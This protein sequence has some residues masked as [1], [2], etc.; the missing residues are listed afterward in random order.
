[1]NILF[2]ANT[3]EMYGANNSLVDMLEELTKRNIN[4]YVVVMNNGGLVRKLRKLGIKSFVVPYF[5]NSSTEGSLSYWE[6]FE[7]LVSNIKLLPRIGEIIKKYNIDVIHSNASNIDIG[8]MAAIKYHIPHVWHFREMLYEDYGLKLDFPLVSKYLMKKSERI[9]AISEYVKKERKLGENSRVLYDGFSI[10]KYIISKENYFINKKL[11]ILYCGVISKQKG[12]IDI[13]KAVEY[14]IRSGNRD[15]ELEIVGGETKYWSSIAQ[16]IKKHRLNDYVKYH[17]FQS[18]MRPFREKADVAVMTSR[19]EALGR[20]TVESMLGEALVIGAD[21]G[22]TS[23][24]IIDGETGYLYVPG[25]I[26]QLA[27]IIKN[28]PKNKEKNKVIVKNAKAYAIDNFDRAAYV[29]KLMDI[30]GAV[31]LNK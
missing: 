13:V 28:I 7:H 21:C 4:V 23:E 8:A 11:H 18:D 31:L 6:K 9:V 25:N 27:N 29:D 3:A 26:V 5:A 16:Y 1:V 22:A 15:I 19:S 20:V 2:F 14:L 17:G 12:I 10:E 30:Y 24:L